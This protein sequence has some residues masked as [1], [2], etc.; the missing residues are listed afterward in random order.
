MAVL[1]PGPLRA[2]E[3]V[4]GVAEQVQ[5]VARCPEA[6]RRTTVDVVEQTQHADDR[7]RVDRRRT[8]LVV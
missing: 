7:R 2:A 5:R 8:G 6:H 3:L 1:G 4:L